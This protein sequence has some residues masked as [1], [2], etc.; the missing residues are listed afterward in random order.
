MRRIVIT[1][2]GGFIGSHIAGYFE[3]MGEDV[4]A[5][6]RKDADLRKPDDVLE[7]CRDASCVIHNAA[8]AADWGRYEDFYE[9][10]VTGTLNVLKACVRNGVGHVILTGSCSVYGEEDCSFIKDENSPLH[11]HY[12]YFLDKVF[13]C[14]MNYYRDT[15]R[16][17]REQAIEF[18]RDNSLRLTIIDPVW[19]Y[20]E[21]EFH[22][23]FYAYL[24]A[25][26]DRI[27]LS[28]GGK[29][30]R[31]HVI[32]AR[33]LARAYYL[34]YKTKTAG[35]FIIGNRETAC[36]DEVFALF[37]EESGYA[38]PRSAP[39]AL[40]YPIGF[41]AELLWTIF[42]AKKPPLMT[43]GR[44]NMFYDSAS[45]GV[46]KAKDM[47]GFESEYTLAQGIKKTVNWY[48]ENGYL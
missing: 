22:S 18:A 29:K 25:A 38:K 48:K 20:G 3:E 7:A 12:T 17:A 16:I 45:Y 43:R 15:K 32:Y 34:A 30:N 39:K 2:G 8:M 44:V 21:R 28:M 26:R 19:V 47:L 31:F 10:N 4:R 5:L 37:C 9:N 35:C 40:M 33:D 14:A 13:P 11:S 23:V 41:A 6:T 27:P 24:K 42:R 1:G 36:M 46:Q